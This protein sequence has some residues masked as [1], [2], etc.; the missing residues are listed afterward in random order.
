M[1]PQE[2][3]DAARQEA[4]QSGEE[5]AEY[6]T[7]APVLRL[8]VALY[9]NAWFEL[10]TERR[11]ARLEPIKRSSVFEYARDYELSE[12]QTDDLWFYVSRM[13]HEFLGWYQTQLGNANGNVDR[14]SQ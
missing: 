1:Y 4:E 3:I 8:G 10:D 13:D 6:V 2:V 11:R 7:N 14:P 12:L 5:L 9:Y